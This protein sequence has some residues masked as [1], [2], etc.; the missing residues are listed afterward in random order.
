MKP[1]ETFEVVRTASGEI[2]IRNNVVNEVMHNPVGPWA[3]A[4]LLYIE[5]SKLVQQLI[6]EEQHPLVLFDV[7]LGAAANALAALSAFVRA[8]ETGHPCRPLTIVSFENDLSLLAFVIDNAEKIP[9]MAGRTHIL[10]HLLEHHS[11]TSPDG[12]LNW[13]LH[14]GDFLK[15]AECA[16]QKPDIVFFDP[17]SP[18]VNGD[19]WSV[20]A[21]SKLYACTNF[22]NHPCTV[23]TYSRATPVRTSMLASGFFVGNGPTSGL[24]NETT[25][26]ATHLQLLTDPLGY[27]WFIRWLRSHKR[28]Q[29][30]CD[31]KT[32]DLLTSRILNHQQFMKH[33]KDALL[34]WK[35]LEQPS[36][37]ENYLGWFLARENARPAT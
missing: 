24:K 4:N 17:Y 22:G 28:F 31:N 21:F 2:S 23:Y 29:E 1:F 5:A 16:Q 19:M 13:Y 6:S 15:T 33:H 8:K 20:D 30:P 10:Q 25:Q 12:A 34:D 14:E 3:E 26:A 35:M 11:W 18:A 37:S 32:K 36:E 7:G 27:R 9:Y